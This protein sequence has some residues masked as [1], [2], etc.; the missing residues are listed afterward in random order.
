M[1]LQLTLTSWVEDRL[2]TL[3]KASSQ[4][5]FTT[6]FDNFFA[7]DAA[8]TVNGASLSRAEYA[9]RMFAS[10][11]RDHEVTIVFPGTL[12]IPKDIN[13]VLSVR[14]FFFGFPLKVDGGVDSG[15]MCRAARWESSTMLLSIS[16]RR[17]LA[18]LS[19]RRSTRR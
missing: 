10:Q 3:L 9:K 4:S 14:A 11:A 2:T 1:T 19:P 16:R 6:A 12:E 17:S 18:S 7:H 8:F 13:N 5:D 15:R